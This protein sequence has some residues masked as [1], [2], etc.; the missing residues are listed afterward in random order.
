MKT[1]CNGYELRFDKQLKEWMI[2]DKF[3]CWHGNTLKLQTAVNYCLE[4]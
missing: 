2:I 3:N 4:N 1:N